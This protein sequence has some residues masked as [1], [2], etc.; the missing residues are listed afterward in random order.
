MELPAQLKAEIE[1]RCAAYR[2]SELAAAAAALSERYRKESGRGKRLLTADVEALAY[3]VVRM[4]ATYG[5]VYTALK[6]T[7]A[8]YPGELTGVLDLGA[9]TG[10]GCWAAA[11]LLGENLEMTCLERENAMLRLGSSLMASHPG[12]RNAAWIRQDLTSG[13][14]R[15]HADLV[16]ASYALNEFTPETR[17]EV[18]RAAWDRTDKLLLLIEPGTPVGSGQLRRAKELLTCLG[19]HVIAPCP[20]NEKC[21]LP[22]EDWCHFTCRISRSRLHKA[23]KGGDAPYEDE[24]FSFLAVAKEPGSPAQARVLRHPLKNPGYISLRLCT[25]AG[26]ID[27]TVTKKQGPLFKAARKADP[28]DPFDQP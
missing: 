5:A 15:Q 10:A 9:G 3:A 4:S 28:G 24:K 7:L 8:C 25:K 1:A 17:E 13:P 23:L 2:Q 11:E 26:V 14:I 21:P 27:T 19:G 18:L 22:E 6:H 16:L 20:G 12:L